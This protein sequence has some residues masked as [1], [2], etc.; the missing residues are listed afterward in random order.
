MNSRGKTISENEILRAKLFEKLTKQE[1]KQKG[2][3]WEDW[4]D[5]FWSKKGGNENSDNGFNEF[6]RWV[7]VLNMVNSGNIDIENED[8]ESKDKKTIIEVIKWEKKDLKLNS[9]YLEDH[10]AL[11]DAQGR[12]PDAL[13]CLKNLGFRIQA[14]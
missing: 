8:E 14:Q 11:Y 6:L 3:D 4:Q 7:Q 2:Q 1:A 12:K 5:F 13:E 10:N 9:K